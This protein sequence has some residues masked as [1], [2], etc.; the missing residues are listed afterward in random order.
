MKNVSI[1]R[2][3]WIGFSLG[4]PAK[5]AG[6]IGA[7]VISGA[8]PL[9]RSLARAHA[10]SWILFLCEPAATSENWFIPQTHTPLALIFCSR[11]KIPVAKWIR[12]GAPF[13]AIHQSQVSPPGRICFFFAS[14]EIGKIIKFYPNQYFIMKWKNFSIFKLDSFRDIKNPIVVADNFS[15]WI[16]VNCGVSE[17]NWLECHLSGKA[18]GG[19][20]DYLLKRESI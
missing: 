18:N 10:R 14:D 3:V 9:S 2:E 15:L 17:G 20:I 8:H 16:K 6:S 11:P 4:A 7:V 19:V 12:T 13:P 1:F 5:Q